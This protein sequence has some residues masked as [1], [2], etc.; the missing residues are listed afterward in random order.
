VREKWVGNLTKTRPPTAVG[1]SIS[2]TSDVAMGDPAARACSGFLLGAI[3]DRRSFLGGK[4]PDLQKL[5]YCPFNIFFQSDFPVAPFKS[6]IGVGCKATLFLLHSCAVFTS[7]ILLPLQD[8]PLRPP[9]LYLF[10]IYGVCRKRDQSIKWN[11]RILGT[12]VPLNKGRARAPVSVS[13]IMILYEPYP[14]TDF[15]PNGA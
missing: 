3:L 11:N 4:L 7:S 2:A 8:L 15:I 10:Y 5:T 12:A 6:L 14:A 9:H 13:L 1:S